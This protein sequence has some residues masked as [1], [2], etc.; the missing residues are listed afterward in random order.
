MKKGKMQ[1]RSRIRILYDIIENIHYLREEEGR[2]PPTRVMFF[3]NLSY[4]RFTEYLEELKNRD[5]VSEDEYGLYLTQ[6]GMKF[7]DELK[8]TLMSL[9]AFGFEL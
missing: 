3:A 2:A 4:E 9:R 7:R 5:I 1:Y 8:K 6:K